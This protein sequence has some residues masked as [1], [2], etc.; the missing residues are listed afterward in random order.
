MRAALNYYPDWKPEPRATTRQSLPDVDVSGGRSCDASTT[1]QPD[2][3]PVVKRRLAQVAG[4][5]RDW[6]QRGSAK[7]SLGTLYY[8][9]A[10]LDKVMPSRAFAPT[11]IPLGHGG[12]QL[13]WHSDVT[14]L[15]VEI[16]KPNLVMTL[17]AHKATGNEEEWFDE[18]AI[19]HLSTALWSDFLS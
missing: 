14:E 12:V 17:I 1:S 4:L 10:L 18:E 9:L 16:V 2:W 15:E 19:T 11:I 8:T 7:P 5:Q 3:L 13:V 6:D